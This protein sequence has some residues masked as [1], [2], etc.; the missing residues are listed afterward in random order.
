MNKQQTE[1]INGSLQKWNNILNSN[2]SLSSASGYCS[3]CRKYIIRGEI[4][5]P[6]D[7]TNCLL[8]KAGHGCLE[9]DSIW[10]QIVNIIDYNDWED[11]SLS[12]IDIE[13]G[14]NEIELKELCIQMRDNIANLL[15]E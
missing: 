8:F 12:D 4:N 14:D 7:C 9:D 11:F 2:T 5:E 6:Q 15:K 1:A 10:E 3:L 13:Y